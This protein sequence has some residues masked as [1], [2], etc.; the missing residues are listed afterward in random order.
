M[1][2]VEFS[3][4][5]LIVI[6]SLGAAIGI[7]SGSVYVGGGASA[8]LLGYIAVQTQNTFV[9]GMWFL[10]LLMMALAA[11]KRTADMLL[12]DVA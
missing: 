10:L 9:V 5:T 3:L 11:G 8:V 7:L 2:L 4:L 1:P 6:L 12:G